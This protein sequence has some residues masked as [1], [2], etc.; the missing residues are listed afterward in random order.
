MLYIS[1]FLDIGLLFN[2]EGKVSASRHASTHPRLF[3]DLSKQH[4]LIRDPTDGSGLMRVSVAKGKGFPF[5][6]VLMLQAPC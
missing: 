5:H 3:C 4:I 2:P 6:G 1:H